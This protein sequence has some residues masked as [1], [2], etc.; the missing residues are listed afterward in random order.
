MSELLS[1]VMWAEVSAYKL[2]SSCNYV[3]ERDASH[4]D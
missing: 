1:D 3:T 4:C 2:V